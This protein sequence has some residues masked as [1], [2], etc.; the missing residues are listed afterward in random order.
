[1]QSPRLQPQRSDS[2][3]YTSGAWEFAF[4]ACSQVML[5]LLDCG[6]HFGSLSSNDPD[7]SVCSGFTSISADPHHH[8]EEPGH[9]VSHSFLPLFSH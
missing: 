1:M 4:L 8:P 6:P 2:E 3:G 7:V 5:M 9:S